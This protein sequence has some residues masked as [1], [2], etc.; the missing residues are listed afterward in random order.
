MEDIELGGNKYRIGRLNTFQQLHLSRKIAPILP[1]LI[2]LFSAIA[3][4]PKD[5]EAFDLDNIGTALSPLT[6]A[7]AAM[8][9]ADFDFVVGLCLGVVTRQQGPIWPPIYKQQGGVLMF[10]DIDI[11]GILQLVT[12]VI[13]SNLGPFI[14]GF[15]AKVPVAASPEAAA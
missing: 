8:P 3:S 7:L 14:Q 6:E 2:P 5:T 15:I 10:E 4:R 11:G 13:W 12:K 1:K 9:D